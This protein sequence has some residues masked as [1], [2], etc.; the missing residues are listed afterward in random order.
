[1]SSDLRLFGDLVKRASD[2]LSAATQVAWGVA[3]E[4][5]RGTSKG[6][7]YLPRCGRCMSALG[8]L[9]GFALGNR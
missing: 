1:M 8:A 6:A 2:H 7:E 9:N 5:A 3:Q 4:P